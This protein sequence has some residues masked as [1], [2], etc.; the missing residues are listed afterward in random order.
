MYKKVS[1]LLIFVLV[2]MSFGFSQEYADIVIDVSNDGRVSI[3]G[4][5][6]YEGFENVENSPEYTSKEG[7]YW[8]L[9]ISTGEVFDEYIYEL[10]LPENSQINYVKSSGNFRIESR[11]G[12]IEV[13]GVGEGEELELLVQ[14]K[15]VYNENGSFDSEVLLYAGGILGIFVL[16]GILFYVF[17]NRGSSY[18]SGFHSKVAEN[19]DNPRDDSGI[20]LDLFT[21]RQREI[22][23]IL[24]SNGKVTQREL[25]NRLEIPKSSISRNVKTLE[26]KGVIKKER[27]GQTNYILLVK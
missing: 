13:I 7:E 20:D 22:L 1:F 25:E 16:I 11:D 18:G 6:N 19:E 26:I 21:P 24:I 15:I 17:K 9:N 5:T 8:L 2:L 3:D 27:V 4:K 10:K 12:R 14:Y 23:E